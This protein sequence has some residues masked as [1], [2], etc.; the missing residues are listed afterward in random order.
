[1][2]FVVSI[3]LLTI[4]WWHP[5]FSFTD[6]RPDGITGETGSLALS[7]VGHTP[8]S[9]KFYQPKILQMIVI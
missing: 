3:L 7:I 5:C 6:S 9:E 2:R 1:M 8:I 4:F